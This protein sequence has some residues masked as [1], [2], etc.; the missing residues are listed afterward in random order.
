MPPVTLTIEGSRIDGIA[1]FYTEINRVFMT[2]EDWQLGQSL[3]ALNDMLYGSYGALSE[4]KNATVIWR[5]MEQNR[6]DLGLIA[7]LAWLEAKLLK[8]DHFNTKRISEDIARLL[9]GRGQTFFEL[10]LEVFADHPSIT[11]QAG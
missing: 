7:T 8:P 3:D 1:S 11:L 10:V 6:H 5:D 2:G 9:E 4:Q